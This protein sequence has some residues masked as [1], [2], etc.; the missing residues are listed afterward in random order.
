MPRILYRYLLLE[1][2]HPFAVSLLAFTAI[3]FSGR[4]MQITQMIVARGVGLAEILQSCLYLLPFLLVFT[5]PMAATVGVMLALM[6]LTVDQEI[7][8]MKSAGLSYRQLVAPLAAFALA[9]GLVTLFLTAYASP[10][11]QRAT[12]QLLTEVVK[13]RADLGIKEQVFN[14]DFQRMTLFVNQV[15]PKDGRLMGIFIYDSREAE[16][17][18][19]VFA[20]RGQVKFDQDNEALMLHLEDGYVIR[21]GRELDRR[22]TLQFKTY[23]L[24]LELLAI[25]LKGLKSEVEMYVPDL[26]QAIREQ[27]PGSERYNRLVVELHQRFAMPV[28]ALL[29]CLLAVPL[30]LS[31]VQHGRTWGLV[32][33]LLTFLIYYIVF[34]VSW[35]LAVKAR[36][37]PALAPWLANVLFVFLAAYLWRRTAR[38][39]P[40]LPR[41]LSPRRWLAAVKSR[42]P[43]RT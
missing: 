3:V 33:G 40:L 25:N 19:A 26:L 29:L 5:L 24:P 34:T 36:L 12:R 38:E 35:R 32:M 23:Q 21:W 11:G 28:G 20:Q 6:R 18:L 2:L 43:S 1:I 30:G 27:K 8:A 15:A 41:I 14:T 31:P 37:D 39:L 17:P 13:K 42:S 9:T 4:L 10:W 22:E 16:N 7:I